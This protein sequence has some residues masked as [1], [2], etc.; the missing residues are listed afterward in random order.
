MSCMRRCTQSL[1]CSVCELC[2][3]LKKYVCPLKVYRIPHWLDDCGCAFPPSQE[4]L[5]I[6]SNS[7]N[8]T[9]A[10]AMALQKEEILF[11]GQW[12]LPR[13]DMI[14]PRSPWCTCRKPWW[15]VIV[16]LST[17]STKHIL[18]RIA[19][20]E[21]RY[22]YILIDVLSMNH[23]C[24]QGVPV[25]HPILLVDARGGSISAQTLSVQVGQR[26][27]QIKVV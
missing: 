22:W 14:F 21:V 6:L 1:Q 12:V 4:L 23:G 19:S 18:L 26:R 5:D 7:S 2:V 8:V 24:S 15:C 25:Q 16:M 11:W 13:C 17:S 3:A 20:T 9:E 27:T 10:L